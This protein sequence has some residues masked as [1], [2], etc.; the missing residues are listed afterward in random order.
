MMLYTV[1]T[2]CELEEC[3]TRMEAI[4]TQQL[5]VAAAIWHF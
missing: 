2:M 4:L 5:H 3:D 1:A